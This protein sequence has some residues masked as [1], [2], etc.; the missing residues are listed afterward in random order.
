MCSGGGGGGG[1][2]ETGIVGQNP[3]GSYIMGDKAY[4]SAGHYALDSLKTNLVG[5]PS[6][7]RPIGGAPPPP[8][9]PPPGTQ[10]RPTPQG[11]SAP[12]EP[13]SRVGGEGTRVSRPSTQTSRNSGINALDVGDTR[14]GG[15][16]SN[17]GLYM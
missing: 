8:G 3:D 16:Q 17:S 12:S 4:D 11:G 15:R 6:T 14:R 9:A 1:Q 7:G 2:D 10:P 13:V 5:T